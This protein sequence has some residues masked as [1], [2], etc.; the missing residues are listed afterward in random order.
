MVIASGCCV[1]SCLWLPVFICKICDK[2]AANGKMILL[3]LVGFY[4]RFLLLPMLPPQ[5]KKQSKLNLKLLVGPKFFF[6]QSL[7]SYLGQPINLS[8]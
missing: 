6:Q 7:N 5:P 8:I 2:D 4:V 1:C 3:S